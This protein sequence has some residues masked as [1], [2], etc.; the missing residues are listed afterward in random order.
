[1]RLNIKRENKKEKRK[2]SPG[3]KMNKNMLGLGYGVVILFMCLMVYM[4]YFLTVQKEEIIGNPYNNPRLDKFSGQVERG[5]IL[6]NDRT[7]L[8][9]TR[10]GE[11]GEEIRVYPF[12]ELFAHG[13]GY[14]TRGKT[15]LEALGGGTLEADGGRRRLGLEGRR[16][17]GPS[18][19]GRGGA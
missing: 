4:V 14:S 3:E 16:T 6:G 9:E 1:M 12:G 8:A 13:V 19:G 5:R 15:G 17:W 7:V 11:N 2:P 18:P 10:T